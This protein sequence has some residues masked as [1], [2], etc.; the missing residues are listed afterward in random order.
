[1][2]ARLRITVRYLTMDSRGPDD[3]VEA[4]ILPVDESYQIEP[5]AAALVLVDTWNKHPIRSHQEATDRVMRERIAPLLTAVRAAGLPVI[6]APSPDVATR[7]EQWRR[8]FGG[9]HP[10]APGRAVAPSGEW[11]PP[12]LRRREG[13]YA[14][15]RRRPGETWPGWD[16][17]VPWDAIADSI[18]P[19]PSDCVVANGDELHELLTER[20]S[21]FLFYAGFATNIC[22]LH[23][24]YGVLAMGARGYLPVL[25]RDCTIGIETRATLGGHLTTRLAIQDVERRYYSADSQDLLDSCRAIVADR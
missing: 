22:V 17:R 25:L 8:R 18:A 6:Y 3:N 7:Y 14:R 20:G 4:N 10:A 15:Y 21:L 1:M 24:D 9:S 5:G 11:P 19:A 16:G 23:R 12:E 13:P 2:T